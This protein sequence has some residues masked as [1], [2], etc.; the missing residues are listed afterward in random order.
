LRKLIEPRFV[1]VMPRLM[2]VGR[3]QID[4]DVI[5][6]LRGRLASGT[7]GMSALNPCPAP[8]VSPLLLSPKYEPREDSEKN[9]K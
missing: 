6:R 4:V 9:N 2:L 8:D 1:Q 7:S 3:D 5:V